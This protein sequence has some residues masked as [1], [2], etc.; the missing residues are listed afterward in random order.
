MI[1]F[2]FSFMSCF[3]L[4]QVRHLTFVKDLVKPAIVYTLEHKVSLYS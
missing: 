4:R 1:F 2:L 3:A